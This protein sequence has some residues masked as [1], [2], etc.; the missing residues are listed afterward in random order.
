MFPSHDPARIRPT[1][2]NREVLVEMPIPLFLSL[3]DATDFNIVE[4]QQKQARINKSLDDGEQLK[5]IPFLIANMPEIGRLQVTGHEGRNR[6]KVLMDRG[7]TSIPVVFKVAEG[8]GAG[9]TIR[10]DQYD[11]PSRGS[12]YEYLTPDEWPKFIVSQSGDEPH[13]IVTGKHHRN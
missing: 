11:D 4:N 9:K 7:Y 6:A 3:A 5:E 12:S 2:K 13:P 10:W 1:S 8:G